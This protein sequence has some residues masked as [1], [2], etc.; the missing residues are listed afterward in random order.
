MTSLQTHSR[1]PVA[2]LPEGDRATFV[3][4]VYQHVLG[5]I[6][7]F[8]AFEAL[9]FTTGVAGRMY[10]FF[11]AGSGMR[12]LAFLGLF[13]VGN[14]FATGAAT[15]LDNPAAQ[16]AGL[17]GTAFMEALIF[18]PFL[19]YVYN[20]AD[21]GS[22]VLAAGAITAIGFVLLS[23]VA[24]VTR[25]DLSGM[26]S[27]LMWGAIGAMALIGGSLLFNFDLGIWFSVAM[28]LLAGG[29]ILYQTQNIIRRY[30][31]HAYVAGAVQLFGS[32]MMMFWYVLRLLMALM[33]D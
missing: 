10:D 7:A 25:K 24:F 29:M 27:F 9:L 3:I 13:M 16:Y 32:L 20:V 15:K 31:S 17:F 28:I 12:W 14:W 8:I 18:A 23:G 5:A 6:G 11:F 30:P 4:K 1:T 19:Y 21:S 33:S 2:N 26:R 22:T